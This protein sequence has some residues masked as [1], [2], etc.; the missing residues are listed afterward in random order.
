MIIKKST[1]LFQ[2]GIEISF[3]ILVT[4]TMKSYNYN[5]IPKDRHDKTR[6]DKQNRSMDSM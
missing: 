6:Q 5:S 4:S 3:P 1:K 2:S